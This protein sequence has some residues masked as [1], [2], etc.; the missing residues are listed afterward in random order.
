MVPASLLIGHQNILWKSPSVTR[1]MGVKEGDNELNSLSQALSMQ[2]GT[3][4]AATSMI[5]LIGFS[6]RQHGGLRYFAVEY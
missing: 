2:Q 5:V 3:A 1:N 6:F 4:K